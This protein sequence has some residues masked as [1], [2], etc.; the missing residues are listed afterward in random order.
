MGLKLE[1]A[2]WAMQWVP[3]LSMI[4][5][6]H[7]KRCIQRPNSAS[8]TAVVLQWNALT[9][10]SSCRQSPTGSA[11]LCPT[12]G[13]PEATE[14]RQCRA[15]RHRFGSVTNSSAL[16]PATVTGGA[17]AT[18]AVVQPEV[19][20]VV[21]FAALSGLRRTRRGWTCEPELP[22]RYAWCNPFWPAVRARRRSGSTKSAVGLR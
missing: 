8:W 20:V 4:P 16:L 19:R 22:T 7:P 10:L 2:L 11:S 5:L 21:S 15:T 14:R 9:I 12:A 6:L 13:R 17:R 3:Q 18:R 1:G